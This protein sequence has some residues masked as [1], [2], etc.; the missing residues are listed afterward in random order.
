MVDLQ[1]KEANT[2][3]NKCGCNWIRGPTHHGALLLH[4]IIFKIQKNKNKIAS[5][6]QVPE[7]SCVSIRKGVENIHVDRAPMNLTLHLLPLESVHVVMGGGGGVQE[8]EY[9]L[10]QIRLC[11]ELLFM[12]GILW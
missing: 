6:L 7:H 11:N 5:Q 10:I 2:L 8:K 9:L 12:K 4:L 3:C 1:L